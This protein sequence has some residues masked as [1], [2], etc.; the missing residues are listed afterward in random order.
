MSM[1]SANLLRFQSRDDTN[2]TKHVNLKEISKDSIR[3]EHIYKTAVEVFPN[4][5]Y[6]TYELLVADPS[7][8][9]IKVFQYISIMDFKIANQKLI[10]GPNNMNIYINSS[11]RHHEQLPYTYIQ[12]LDEVSANL[13]KSG[14]I[15]DY[16]LSYCMLYNNCHWHSSYCTDILKCFI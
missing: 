5:I 6:A 2:V 13:K 7:S 14:Y 9:F 16:D 1:A 10:I 12:N 11:D 8:T 4:Y 3:N 15:N